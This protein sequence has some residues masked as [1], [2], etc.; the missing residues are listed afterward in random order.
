M[1]VCK[2]EWLGQRVLGVE[3]GALTEVPVYESHKRGKNWL[4]VIQIDPTAPGGLRRTFQRRAYGDYF[5]MIDGLARG[6]AVEFG[7]DYYTGVGRKHATR[8]YGVV[9]CVLK[10]GLILEAVATGIQACRAAESAAWPEDRI[11][12]VA[13]QDR[14]VDVSPVV[15]VRDV[16]AISES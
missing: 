8:W 3:A 10:D 14:N 1:G 15:E 11:P 16:K 7:A 9:R 6:M 5:Y 4:A 2:I 13:R 12:E